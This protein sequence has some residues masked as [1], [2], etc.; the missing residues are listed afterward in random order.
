MSER[1]AAEEA[2]GKAAVKELWTSSYQPVL[3]FTP[4]DFD[5]G[6]L[7][8][9]MLYMSRRGY[10]RGLGGFV[11][12]FAPKKGVK[13]SVEHVTRTL[14]G[15]TE[16]FAGFDDP[17]GAVLLA[18]LL[19]CH[20]LEN[21]GHATGRNVQVQRV[22]STHYLVS[23]VDLP[24]TLSALRSVPEMIVMTLADQKD[25]EFL[26]LGA[27]SRFPVGVL[28]S[29]NLLTDLLAEG[30]G[31]GDQTSSLTSERFEEDAEVGI[32]QLLTIRLAEACGG[33]PG[34]VTASQYDSRISNQ[35][36]LC[37]EAPRNFRGDVTAFLLGHGRSIPRQAMLPM[38][39]AAFGLNLAALLRSTIFSVLHWGANGTLPASEQA[40]PLFVD[41]SQGVDHPLRRASE[42]SFDQCHRE[43]EAVPAALMA[44]RITGYLASK[45]D[46]RLSDRLPP[47]WPHAGE[48]LRVLGDLLHHRHARSEK[49]ADNAFEWCEQLADALQE[50]EI[51]PELEARLRTGS[52]SEPVRTLAEVLT[53]MIGEKQQF[54]HFRPC[55][56]AMLMRGT[57]QPL[58]SL[59]RIN[60]NA[61]TGRKTRDVRS[62][63]LSNA[64]LDFL[65]HRHL[66][67][68]DGSGQP[69]DAHL[70]FS[71]FVDRLRERYGLYVD[72]APPGVPVARELLL[73]NRRE[74]ERRLR[75]LGLLTG[76]NDAESMK[77]LRR[78]FPLAA[79]TPSAAET[80]PDAEAGAAA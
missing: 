44:M 27:A 70:S 49:L 76:V 36:P 69:V 17:A 24:S 3:P 56:D 6:S 28:P 11:K 4:Q 22:Y 8:P 37:E 25:G 9:V 32:D 10:R 15:D 51:R 5:I 18:D 41:C 31:I 63:V 39:E 65:V 67:E 47:S 1:K 35:H 55:L 2:M 64:A 59:R 14:L 34:R 52:K 79:A 7:M 74:L 43:L 80:E 73:R 26:E 29:K 75:D 42:A 53:E 54:G 30:V 58:V 72:A 16:A 12:T 20:C 68:L 62:A 46:R 57:A 48:Y 66:C 71:G 21:K 78:R 19:L 50:K 77:K 61:T 60:T 38:L 23:H 13:P 33:A 45:K 40:V